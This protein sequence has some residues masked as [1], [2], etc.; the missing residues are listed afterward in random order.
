MEPPTAATKRVFPMRPRFS[1][2]KRWIAVW[3]PRMI[4]MRSARPRRLRVCSI[5][6]MSGVRI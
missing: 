5:V 6:V 3:M 4:R 2:L 1:G